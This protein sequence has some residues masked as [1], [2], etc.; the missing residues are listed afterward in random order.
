MAI[1]SDT[2]NERATV[3]ACCFVATA[4]ALAAAD[5]TII[6]LLAGQVHPFVIGLFRSV[7]GLIL[8]VAVNSLAKRTTKAGLF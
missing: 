6:R 5:A 2:S 7:V 3:L 4:A 1:I 8:L